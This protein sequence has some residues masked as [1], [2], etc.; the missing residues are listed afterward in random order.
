MAKSATPNTGAFTPVPIS[1]L[2]ARLGMSR[3]S[4]V[5]AC[6]RAMEDVFAKG[7][8]VVR[9]PAWL[10]DGVLYLMPAD[11]SPGK[12]RRWKS[13]TA[14]AIVCIWEARNGGAK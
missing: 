13:A 2:A 5:R 1:V 3:D 7:G 9:P 12:H 8:R 14:D 6:N 10:V 4:V 11:A